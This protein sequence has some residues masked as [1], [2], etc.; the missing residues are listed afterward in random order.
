MSDELE[1]GV[2]GDSGPRH[3]AGNQCDGNRRRG[4]RRNQVLGGQP[5]AA[6]DAAD[7]DFRQPAQRAGGGGRCLD[8]L[9]IPRSPCDAEH[10]AE[11]NAARPTGIR[12]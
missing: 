4:A 10:G 6:L 11:R 12:T 8:L 2:L 5:F 3:L 1:H 7:Q 9:V